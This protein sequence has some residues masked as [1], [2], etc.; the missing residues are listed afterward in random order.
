MKRYP[1]MWFAVLFLL[2][3]LPG[4]P[5]RAQ[6]AQS[7]FKSPPVRFRPEVRWFWPGGDV[8]DAELA[9]EI[10]EM[11][12]AGWGGAEIQ[13]LNFGL[14][15]NIYTS[16]PIPSMP[17]DMQRRVNDYLTPS[18]FSHV[19]AA[20]E[21]AHSH[22]MWVD[23][24]FGSGWPFGGA[25]GFVT[26]KI[27]SVELISAHQTIRGP[28]HFHARLRMPQ[29]RPAI[30]AELAALP[31]A[32][33]KEFRKREKLVAV[34]AA[35]G[36]SVTLFPTQPINLISL[37]SEV[38]KPG[39]LIP[40]SSVVLTGR[41][42]PDGTLDWNVPPGVWQVFT[43]EEVPTGQEVGGGAGPGIQLVLDHMS[44]SA[45]EAYAGRV[46]GP[47]K[48]YDGRFFGNTLQA[49]F[50]DSLEVLSN[51]YWDDDF[52]EEFSK[53]RGYDLTPYLPIL[54]VP[55]ANVPYDATAAG[56]PLYDIRGIGN[57]VR[58]D[59]WQT[60][61]DVMIG[62]F[63]EPFNQWAADNHLRSRVQAHGSP[64]D[65]LRVYGEASI[66]ETESLY[67]SGRYDF[68][69]MASSA[70]DLYGR[71]VVSSESFVWENQLYETTPQK[72][73][74]F[75]DQL[76]TAGINRIVF[77]GFPYRFMNRPYPGWYPF[78]YA[79]AYSS[80]I[81]PTNTFWPFFSQLNAYITRL[82]YILQTGSTVVPIALYT[83]KLAYDAVEPWPPA[84]PIDTRL[85]NAGYNFDHIDASVLL[86]C[87]VQAGKLVSPGGAR[88]GALVV[89]RQ[90]A[91]P[92]AIASRL[93]A[94][95]GEGLPIVFVGGAPGVIPPVEN[96]KPEPGLE[97]GAFRDLIG[98]Q[99]ILTAANA[100]ETVAALSRASIAPNL[101]FQGR[102]L[103]F[104]EKRIGRLDAFFFRNPTDT[105]VATAALFP[106]SGAPQWWNPWTGG[107]RSMKDFR[108]EGTQTRVAFKLAPYGSALLVFGA[109][110]VSSQAA[111]TPHGPLGFAAA[112]PASLPTHTLAVQ[113]IG[114]EGWRFH[115]AGIGPGGRKETVDLQFPGLAD[116]ASISRLKNFSGRGEYTTGF[117]VPTDWLEHGRHVILD[118]GSVKNAAQVFI[119]GASGPALILP[120]FESD[121][122][123]LVHAGKNTLRV[124]V[125]NALF[126]ALSA[127]VPTLKESPEAIDMP[128]HLLP[129]GLIGP[130]VLRSEE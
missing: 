9:R 70:G 64:T 69:K 115:G 37:G 43:F 108:R 10:D 111:D 44:R 57:R 27:S 35:R 123:P 65:A 14:V 68:L 97:A 82:Q 39:E 38:Q 90:N 33:V 81:N 102:P 113:T 12:R 128:D 5:L 60:V 91:V 15:S 7:D 72:I 85:M 34:V 21:A 55:G 77:A 121:V 112:L 61:S 36:S 106:D 88:Y 42:E 41:M 29:L 110:P 2:L 19:R 17:R 23:F 4:N 66:P 3:L 51:L 130:V 25:A 93:R 76:F 78:T 71:K 58:R 125:Y 92:A 118:L 89:P 62:N 63:Y 107:I 127:N 56:L 53:L 120:P 126:N 11:Y 74:R 45:F 117:T 13:P 75:A 46:G 104:I 8:D 73:K 103:Y 122:T 124:V 28:V 1:V 129:S 24:T 31:A 49:V 95:A 20:L 79:G 40:G 83:G 99:R 6:Q 96:G 30:Q 101:Q 84:P 50:C 47:L 98:S 119:D 105:P 54:K 67:D 26:P 87:R 86:H 52:L 59:Y 109:A 22:G 94:F 100:A 48:K 18:F 116:W 32:W 80:D 114:S 16:G